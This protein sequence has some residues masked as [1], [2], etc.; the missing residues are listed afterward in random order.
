MSIVS[1]Q[2]ELIETQLINLC[3]EIIPYYAVK[4]ALI[5]TGAFIMFYMNMT[6]NN[7]SMLGWCCTIF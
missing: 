5:H 1:I 6:K 2:I 4:C 3:G 7:D